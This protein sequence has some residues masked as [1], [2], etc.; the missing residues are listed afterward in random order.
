M[1]YMPLI[2][3]PFKPNE[4]LHPQPK[5]LFRVLVAFMCSLFTLPA[6]ANGPGLFEIVNADFRVENEI[7]VADARADLS[8]SAEAER[9][10]ENGVTLTIQYQYMVNRA[11]NFWPDKLIAEP[12]ENIELQYLSLSRRYVVRNTDTGEQE[13]Y[14]TMFSALRQI[15]RVRDFPI[16]AQSAIDSDERYYISMR[17]VLSREKLPGPM[18]V[19]LFWQGDFSLESE[20]F[21]WTIK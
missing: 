15:G 16:I 19:L 7:W 17:V 4:M 10:L 13:S 8:L 9:A 3:S 21:R 6:F 2:H 14:A 11:R 12:S 18:Q 20:W 1:H 5:F